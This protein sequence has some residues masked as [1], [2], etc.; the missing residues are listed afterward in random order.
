MNTGRIAISA[1]LA[2]AL[3]GVLFPVASALGETSSPMPKAAQEEYRTK[4]KAYSCDALDEAMS[5]SYVV[6]CL[7]DIMRDPRDKMVAGFGAVQFKLE[8]KEYKSRCKEEPAKLKAQKK[9]NG[10]KT[11]TM[12]PSA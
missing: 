10:N 6:A 8:Q 1:A 9:S 5:K 11:C 3:F 2:C 4:L 12:V 7:G